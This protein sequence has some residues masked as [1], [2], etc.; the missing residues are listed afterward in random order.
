MKAARKH[1]AIL[2]V[3]LMLR[4]P[5]AEA[6]DVANS[7]AAG[8]NSTA[9]AACPLDLGY[10]ATLPWD[11]TPCVP[12]VANTTACCMTLLS[13]LAVGLAAR[14]RATGRFR[15]PSAP[16]SASCL[17]AFAGALAAP[18][19]SLP[20]SLVPGCFP[21]P[22]Q[23]AITPDYCAGVTTAAEYAAVAGD[24]SV[25]GLNA[26]CGADI[27]SMSTCTRC[28]NAGVGASARLTAAA[29]NSSKSQNCFYLTVLY[30]AGISSSAG[31]DSPA[32]ASCALGLAL[33]TPSSPA[34]PASSSTNHT[35]IAVAAT[36]PIASVL[37]VSLVALLLWRK[38][39]GD[40][41]MRSI[42][43]SESS[44]GSRP[45]PNTG[46]VMFDVREL[47]K[48]T[49]GFAERNLIGRGGF[50]VVYRGVLADGTVVAVK[51][52]LDPDVEGGDE[53][54][55]N[56]VEIISLLRHRNLVPLRGCC[57]ADDDPDEGKQMFLVYDYMPKGSL[58]QYIFEDGGDGRRRPAL[59]W[60][61]R[62]AVI[63]DVARGLEYLHYGVKP[64]IY[65]RDIKATN[66]LLDADMRARVADFGLARRSREGQSHLTTRVAG[67]HGYL[68]PEYALYGQLTEKSDVYSFGVLVLEAMSG[69]RAIDLSDPSG[70]VLI[71]DWAWTHVK[72][73]RPREVLAGA[74]RKEPSAVVAAMERFMLVGILCA[75]VTVACRP[76]MPEALRMLE[77]DMD[78]PDLPDRPQAFGQRIAFDEGESNFSASSILSGPFVDFGD[79][80]R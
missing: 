53:E 20:A 69:R 26:S 59:S 62:R 58:D 55:T 37:L 65:H 38:R 19:L 60:A 17:R 22:S 80:L 10:V 41:K 5:A 16:A 72:A 12:P 7:T 13:V 28:L 66:I 4:P 43:I 18:P 70:V 45:R 63:L 3:V 50:G 51:K 57:I 23:F 52:M 56:E 76:T 74:L 39:R 47:A 2:F 49:G 54:F 71:T 1:L 9:A 68:S 79:M 11:R 35:N 40:T 61:Q 78:V 44:R 29:G 33:S 6:D 24:A 14:L 77:G 30:A 36:I 42:Q 73:G 64:G 8:G 67:T 46:S 32:T 15:L 31:P 27:T 48:A 25:A 75:H 21:V 34:S